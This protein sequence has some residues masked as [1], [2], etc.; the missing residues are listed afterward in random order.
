MVV[1]ISPQKN[2]LSSGQLHVVSLFTMFESEGYLLPG[3]GGGVL[4][5]IAYT[6][7]LPPRRGYLFCEKWYMYISI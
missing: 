6:E 4:P 7:G 5:M 3:V 1:T 2:N